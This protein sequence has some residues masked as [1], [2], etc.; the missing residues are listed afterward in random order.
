[1]VGRLAMPMV[2]V[3]T[4]WGLGAAV[5]ARNNRDRRPVERRHEPGWAKQPQGEQDR[6]QGA[7]HRA[8]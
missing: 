3:L 1:M 5:G 8:R 6:K 4:R 7:A 2:H